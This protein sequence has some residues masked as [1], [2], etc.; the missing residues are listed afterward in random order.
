M[1][2]RVV[3]V[4]AALALGVAGAC[5]LNP[6]PL[7]PGEPDGSIDAAG[8]L[9]DSSADAFGFEDSSPTPGGE[10]ADADATTTSS[11]ASDGET[12]AADAETDADL[13]ARDE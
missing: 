6:Q 12:D 8:A 5:S 3:L 2:H 11:D 13:D 10:D 9:A 4:A 1:R 7:P